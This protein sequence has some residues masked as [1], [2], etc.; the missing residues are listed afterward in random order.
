MPY[1]EEDTSPR[2]LPRGQEIQQKAFQQA[3]T[4]AKEPKPEPEQGPEPLQDA[5]WGDLTSALL[6]PT[7]RPQEPLTTPANPPQEDRSIEAYL[8]LLNNQRI[9]SE[10]RSFLDLLI[11]VKLGQPPTGPSSEGTPLG[12]PLPD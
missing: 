5:E 8:P 7:K 12:V 3:T 9:S 10:T 2:G 1:A 6:G 11:R 4:P